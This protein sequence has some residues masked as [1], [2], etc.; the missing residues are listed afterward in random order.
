[1][2]Y[3]NWNGSM[4]EM[5]LWNQVKC[6]DEHV[7]VAN[8]IKRKKWNYAAKKKKLEWNKTGTNKTCRII[9]ITIFIVLLYLLLLL[10]I[11]YIYYLLLLVLQNLERNEI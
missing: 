1:M 9:I 4:D 6:N 7:K 2:K 5:D 10:S 11:S 8:I 3:T